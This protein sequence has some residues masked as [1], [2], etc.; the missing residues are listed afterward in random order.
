MQVK[1]SSNWRCWGRAYAHAIRR[2]QRQAQFL[3][4]FHGRLIARF[5]F[6]MEVPLEFDIN[7]IPAKHGAELLHHVDRAP[8]SP[9]GQSMR[10]GTFFSARQAN[11][12]LRLRR[13]LFRESITFSFFPSQFHLRDQP[14]KV[15][16]TG[17]RFDEQGIAPALR[18]RHFGADV[19]ANGYLPGRHM[20]TW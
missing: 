17:A 15:L 2:E 10:Q 3:R 19:S 12:S 6:A 4:D 7:I 8:D 18:G 14:A 11:Q 16:I 13:H 20:K 5:F 9:L 1:T